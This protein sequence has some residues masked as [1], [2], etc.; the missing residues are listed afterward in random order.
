MDSTSLSPSHHQEAGEAAIL[1]RGGL[2]VL[3]DA[4]QVQLL[5]QQ[6]LALILQM[7]PGILGAAEVA[8]PI[9]KAALLGAQ[10]KAGRGGCESVR[11]VGYFY[12]SGQGA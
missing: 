8:A 7:G 3:L 12:F 5:P 1:S 2:D 6:P 10:G 4:S 9:G 11:L